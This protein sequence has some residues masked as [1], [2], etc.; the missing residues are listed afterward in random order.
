MMGYFKKHET[1]E[2]PW[3]D[4][5]KQFISTKLKTYSWVFETNFRLQTITEQAEN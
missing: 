5:S 3:K 1:Y 2:G 4:I